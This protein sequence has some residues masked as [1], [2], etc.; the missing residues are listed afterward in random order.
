MSMASAIIY[1]DLGIHKLTSCAMMPS[2][3]AS[4]EATDKWLRSH[5]S[6]GL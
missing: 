4:R 3:V 2:V 6:N 1:C 5:P